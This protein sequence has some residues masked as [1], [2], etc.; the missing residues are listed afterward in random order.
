MSKPPASTF[1][2]NG[3]DYASADLSAEGRRLVALLNQAQAELTRL[4]GQIALIQ[5]GQK[6]LL[7]QLK[8]LLPAAGSSNAAPTA[9]TPTTGPAM[10]GMASE[11]IPTTPVEKPDQEPDPLPDTIPDAIRAR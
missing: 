5:A 7:S 10:L 8:P 4:Q 1:Q 2:L 3:I 11:Q 9:T 6:Q